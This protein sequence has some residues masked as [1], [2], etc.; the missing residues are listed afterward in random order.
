MNPEDLG[1]IRVGATAQNFKPYLDG[2]IEALQ[3]AVVNSVLSA[4]NNGTLTPDM[5]LS[6]WMEY[7]AYKKLSQKFDQRIEVGKSVGAKIGPKLDFDL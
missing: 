4:V 1:A 2:E 7:I 6:K 3:K 5:A